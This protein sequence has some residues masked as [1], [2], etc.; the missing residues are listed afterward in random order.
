VTAAVAPDA[1]SAAELSVAIAH[2]V[3]DMAR[4]LGAPSSMPVVPESGMI[5]IAGASLLGLGMIVRRSTRV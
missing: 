2:P 5:L 4:R 3:G 1:A